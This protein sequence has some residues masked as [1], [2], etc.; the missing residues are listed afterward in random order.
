MDRFVTNEKTYAFLIF[1]SLIQSDFKR[2]DR[3]SKQPLMYTP[4]VYRCIKIRVGPFSP[5]QTTSC[6][7]ISHIIQ[8]IDLKLCSSLKHLI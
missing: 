4:I 1:M 3:F 2:K 6:F 8:Y 5:S 7:C